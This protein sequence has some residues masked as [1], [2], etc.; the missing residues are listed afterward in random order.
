MGRSADTMPTIPDTEA[1]S[2]VVDRAEKAHVEVEAVD[3]PR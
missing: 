2:Q 3:K 1:R